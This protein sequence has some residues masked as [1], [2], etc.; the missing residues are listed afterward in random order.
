MDQ[1]TTSPN[2]ADSQDQSKTTNDG[3]NDNS[4][5]RTDQSSTSPTDQ[6]AMPA[7]D[8]WATSET[9]D[10]PVMSAD[11]IIG[12]L[13]Q[14]PTILANVKE[15]AAQQAGVDP[16]TI[17]DE[18]LYARIQQD[19]N[20][21]AQLTP[22]LNKLGF[23][24]DVGLA[25]KNSTIG[26]Q[27]RGPVKPQT[28]Q[29]QPT[30]DVDLD[31][32]HMVQRPNPYKNLPSLRD[33]YTQIPSAGGQL[34]RFGSDAFLVDSGN[35]NE[36]PMDLPVGPDYVL[37][38]GDNIIV[39]MWGG[40]SA[41]LSMTIDRQGQIA[42]PEA[43]TVNLDSLTIAQ[44]QAAIQKSLGTQYQDEH[45]EIS[46][47]RLRTVRVYVVGDVQ[48]PGPYDVSSMSTPLSALFAA[49]G[50]TSRGSLRVMRQYR[51]NNLVREI[52]LYDLLLRG[53]RSN[54]DRLLPGDT[55]LVPP[56]GPQV[57]VEGMVHRP[58][59]YELNGEQKSEPGSGPC[60]EAH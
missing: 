45:A 35:T 55:I 33:L 36:L 1:Q 13:R 26:G 59:I 60:G 17:T 32:P 53:V 46:L 21:R 31:K 22:E 9:T 16:S 8:P 38:P 5:Q 4:A 7:T 27:S 43:G 52:D 50:P 49:G 42:L 40:R 41:R 56:Y 3:Q 28:A 15:A 12:I 14:E 37:G 11:Q 10:Q 18:T 23:S 25:T 47:G 29:Q 48:R 2:K 58:A 44:A 6:S 24:T 39:N 20:V 19:A 51:G 34:R 57:T 54:N 30:P